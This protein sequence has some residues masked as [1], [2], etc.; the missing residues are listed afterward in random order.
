MIK[1]FLSLAVLAVIAVGCSSDTVGS[2]PEM[3]PADQRKDD[4]KV[5]IGSTPGTTTAG[6]QTGN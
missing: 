3:P 4:N 2:N 5:Q 1:R 6:Q